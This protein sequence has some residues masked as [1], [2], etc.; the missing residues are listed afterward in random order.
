M[1]RVGYEGLKDRWRILPRNAVGVSDAD[2]AFSQEAF[3]EAAKKLGV[4]PDALQGG[5]WFAEKQLWADNGWGRLDLGDFRKEIEK[6]PLL[7][8]G[9]QQRLAGVRAPTTAGPSGAVRKAAEEGTADLLGMIEPRKT[10]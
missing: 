9:I 7:K 3:R 6:T 4:T 2:F 10:R 8:A 1:R 5:L